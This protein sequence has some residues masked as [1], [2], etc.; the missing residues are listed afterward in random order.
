[1]K[2]SVS[3]LMDGQGGCECH[4]CRRGIGAGSTFVMMSGGASA[5]GL[6]LCTYCAMQ[7]V[8]ADASAEIAD[9]RVWP[10]FVSEKR[11]PTERAPSDAP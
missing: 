3:R 4:W 1:M 11:L 8:A 10:E 5:L 9:V 2:Y 6:P 7:R